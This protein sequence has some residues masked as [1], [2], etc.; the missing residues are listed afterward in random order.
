MPLKIIDNISELEDIISN[1]KSKFVLEFAA[2]WSLTCRAVSNNVKK[3][4]K[5]I[6]SVN[7]FLVNVENEG[8]EETLRKYKIYVVPTFLLFEGGN[9][10]RRLCGPST[11][12]TIHNFVEKE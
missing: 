5:E 9:F 1:D 3:V 10:K 7:F 8:I 6:P 12:G 11:R 2:K 4:S